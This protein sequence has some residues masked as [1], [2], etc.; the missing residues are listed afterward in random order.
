MELFNGRISRRQ[1]RESVVSL[2]VG[3]GVG[4]EHDCCTGTEHSVDEPDRGRSEYVSRCS[5]CG[6]LDH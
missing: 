5:R 2:S 6:G 1:T 4:V 3:V